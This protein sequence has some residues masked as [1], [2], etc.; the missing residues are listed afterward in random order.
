MSLL[1]SPVVPFHT[2]AWQ[3]FT[4]IKHS[5]EAQT[6]MAVPT[7]NYKAHATYLGAGILPPFTESEEN[8]LNFHV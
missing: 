2:E 3:F 6:E 1:S 7:S 5:L 8:S 4:S